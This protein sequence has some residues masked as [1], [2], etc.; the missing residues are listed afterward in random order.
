MDKRSD[1]RGVL[2]A[3][4]RSDAASCRV[5]LHVTARG[6]VIAGAAPAVAGAMIHPRGAPARADAAASV[7]ALTA[8]RCHGAGARHASQAVLRRAMLCLVNRTRVAQAWRLSA[9]SATS[10]APPRVTL[11]I[12]ADVTT[13]PTSRRAARV[14]FRAPARRAGVAESARSSRGAAACVRPRA[15]RSA[16]GSPA[17]RTGRSSWAPLARPASASSVSRAAAAAATG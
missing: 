4:L 13:S 14:R 10:R 12:W 3:F 9:P 2:H 6:V 5:H 16:R 7:S 17:R 15:R 1:P 11:P 8:S